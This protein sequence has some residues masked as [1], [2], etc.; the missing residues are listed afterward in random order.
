MTAI[1]VIKRN[2][3]THQSLKLRVVKDD[4][5]VQQLSA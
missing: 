2:E 4:D 1:L 3:F 5:F